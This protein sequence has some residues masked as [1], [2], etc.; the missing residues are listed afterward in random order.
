MAL[1]LKQIK[2]QNQRL[3]DQLKAK[4]ELKKL[5]E[6][7]ISLAEQNKKLLKQLKRSP[8]SK[9]ITRELNKVGRGLFVAGKTIGRGL[10]KY[11]RFLDEVERRNQSRERSLKKVSKSS[12]RRK[13]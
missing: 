2:A 12:S 8:T 9:A 10:I 1:T 13:R 3:R 4:V 6:E 7:R 11:G 5:E